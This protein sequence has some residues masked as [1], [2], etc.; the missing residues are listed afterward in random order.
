MFLLSLVLLSKLLLKGYKTGT[1]KHYAIFDLALFNM[2]LVWFAQILIS[3]MTPIPYYRD[4]WIFIYLEPMSLCLFGYQYAKSTQLLLE[5]QKCDVFLKILKY[6]SFS[7][8]ISLYICASIYEVYIFPVNK[9]RDYIY[10]ETNF[11]EILSVIALITFYLSFAA[12]IFAFIY[13]IFSMILI[14]RYCG[15]IGTENL[16]LDAEGQIIK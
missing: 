2:S 16:L 6:A 1:T 3:F 4:F 11:P 10:D 14:K 8:S 7:C 12:G 13:L 9:T 5:N 15:R